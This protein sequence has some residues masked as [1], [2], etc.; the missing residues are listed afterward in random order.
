MKRT[1][2]FEG[3]Q[4]L[5]ISGKRN[6]QDKL[7]LQP[8]GL[9]DG[10]QFGSIKPEDGRP[11]LLFAPFPMTDGD[12]MPS[13]ARAGDGGWHVWCDVDHPLTPEE[14]NLVA[15]LGGWMVR[16]GTPGHCQVWIKLDRA[17]P[18]HHIEALNR[19]L[20][21]RLNGDTSKISRAAIMRVPGSFNTK[22]GKRR[23]ARIEL[24]SDRVWSAPELASALGTELPDTDAHSRSVA[25]S[26]TPTAIRKDDQRY[27]SVR[28]LIRKAN[29]RFEEGT[30]KT[31][32]KLMYWVGLSCFEAGVEDPGELLW[33]MEQCEAAVSKC[34]DEGKAMSHHVG[35]IIK[36]G[37]SGGSATAEPDTA[38]A[39]L[40]LNER[41]G[42]RDEPA[43]TSADDDAPEAER[44]PSLD[45]ATAW[46]Q[47]YSSPDWLLGKFLERAQQI[48]FV[49]GGKDGKSLLILHWCL[50]LVLGWEFFGDKGDGPENSRKGKGA[51]VLYFDRENNLRDIITRARSLGVTDKDLA[52]LS[53]R[54]VYKQF[55]AFD[56]TLDDPEANAA[57]QLLAIVEEVKPDVVILDT[58]SRF[59]KGNENDSAPWLQLYRLV[60]APL[61]ARGV[62]AVRIDHFGK[63][64]TKGAR[65]N[66]AKA[67]DVDHVW[68]MTV[69]AERKERKPDGEWV[70]ITLGMK[71]THTRTGHG[72][73]SFTVVRRGKKD[74]EGM[75]ADGCT[76]HELEGQ[77]DRFDEVAEG[78]ADAEK[79]WEYMRAR[80][81][82]PVTA[83]AA[84]EVIG[85]S[86][87][88]AER[89]L[90]G[91][92][93]DP[94][95][96]T[97]I[98]KSKVDRANAWTYIGTSVV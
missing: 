1:D 85:K 18:A 63:D 70:V 86:S 92:E 48:A 74:A 14:F 91:F 4:F 71:R 77:Q 80:V 65:G 44:F 26:E 84:A 78:L 17:T 69:K 40:A 51:R 67:Q 55:P 68:E 38:S 3:M 41:A 47:D 58:A 5:V 52:A 60:H 89:I 36:K 98:S 8:I 90:Q 57:E 43:V 22:G 53:E 62:A 15:D 2:P 42:V 27:G 34:S 32:Y 96:K 82:S 95:R 45:W 76:S 19:A 93:R 25:V 64:E 50:A 88:T 75:W 28:T 66:S 11:E 46:T 94:M 35:L 49:A 33:V 6:S 10:A 54:F 31:R 87:K 7:L 56:G 37:R 79:L 81:G 83:R 73:D 16:S 59:I 30:Y 24:R 61:K 20:C 72:A 39:T 9:F 97:Q 29:G 13:I 21:E 23:R 12:A